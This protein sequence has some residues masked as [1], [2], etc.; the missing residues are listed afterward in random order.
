MPLDRIGTVAL[1]E[2]GDVDVWWLGGYGG[3]VF[4]P[5]RDGT[6]FMPHYPELKDLAPRDIVSQAI[7]RCMERTQHP[8]V[9]L[10]LTHLDPAR[11]RERRGVLLGRGKPELQAGAEGNH[12]V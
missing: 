8:N 1:G 11:V 10:D 9:Y 2:L 12:F 7:F 3:G 6:P 5:L 4:L